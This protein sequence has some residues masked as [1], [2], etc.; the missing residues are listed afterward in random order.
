VGIKDLLDQILNSVFYSKSVSKASKMSSNATGILSLLKNVLEKV[1]KEGTSSILNTISK[2]I[3]L[4]VNLIKSYASGEYRDI[5]TKNLVLILA[6]LIYLVSPIDFIPDFIPIL[7]F[8][9]DIAL[10]T[11]VYNAMTDEIDKFEVWT[12]NKDLN[13]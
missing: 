4:L 8:A 2:K 9:D 10:L 7:G 11:F 5:E 1:N 13:K 3:L 6:A 12:L